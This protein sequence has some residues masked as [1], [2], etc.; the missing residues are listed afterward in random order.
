[1]VPSDHN[2]LI[3]VLS[4][5]SGAGKQTLVRKLK[6]RLG[7]VATTTSV[8]TRAPRPGERHGED[9]FFLTPEEF[10]HRRNNDAFAEWAE[11]HGNFYGTLKEELQRCLDQGDDVIMELDVQGMRNLRAL[12]F[13]IL[14]VFLMPPSLE[15]LERR[16]RSRGADSDDDIA[17]RLNNAK[18]EMASRHEFDHVVVNDEIDRAADELERLIHE[19]R[20]QLEQKP[21]TGD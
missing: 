8:T 18:D 15:E 1:M 5:P 10:L 17:L 12:E 20:A 11:V 16:L 2:A 4:A 9:Y 14:S 21:G 13:P 19:A 6:E 7:S 3:L